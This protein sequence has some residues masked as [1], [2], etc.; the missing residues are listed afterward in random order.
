MELLGA[1]KLRHFLACALVTLTASTGFECR[2]VAG[3]EQDLFSMSDRTDLIWISNDYIGIRIKVGDLSGFALI[4]SGTTGTAFDSRI[5]SNLEEQSLLFGKKQARKANTGTGKIE[6][7]EF[8]A[9]R[10]QIE[11]KEVNSLGVAAVDLDVFHQ[12]VGVQVFLI[13]GYEFLRNGALGNEKS[14]NQFYLGR[15]VPDYAWVTSRQTVV[16]DFKLFI[17]ETLPWSKEAVNF[18]VDSG[19]RHPLS[20]DGEHFSKG[21]ASNKIDELKTCV[22]TSLAGETEIRCGRMN[23]EFFGRQFERVPVREAG[24]NRI[25]LQLLERFDFEIDFISNRILIGSNVDTKS[26]FKEDVTG[27]VIGV[28]DD[29]LI[30][31]RNAG[32]ADG[33]LNAL[34]PGDVLQEWDGLVTSIKSLSELRFKLL[35]YPGIQP[36]RLRILRDG[37][38]MEL[39]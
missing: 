9:L 28:R 39:R 35:E 18:M 25:G 27:I 14:K 38:T 7:V 31:V 20:L 26:S 5:T 11:G 16:K 1:M 6:I 37:H 29:V 32:V 22:S 24:S 8:E 36:K 3:Q 30:I 4:D 13:L 21:I 15:R 17:E 10:F 23:I 12:T 2:K 34:K 19:D 33:L